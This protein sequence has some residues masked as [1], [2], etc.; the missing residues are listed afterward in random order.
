MN[1]SWLESKAYWTHVASMRASIMRDAMTATTEA[2]T[3]EAFQKQLYYY[4]RMNT[5]VELSFR[6]ETPIRE[7]LVHN[8]GVLKDR[9]SGR[10]RLDAVVNNLLIEYKKHKKLEKEADQQTAIHQV[11]DYLQTLYENEKVQYSAILTDGV[12]I[13]YF[14]FRG[15]TIESTQ[16]KAMEDE[17]IDRIIRAILTNNSKKLISENIYKDFSVDGLTES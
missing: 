14:G 17:D 13:S 15:N 9:T 8:F 1:D 4:I 5:G 16:L 2:Q 12:Q 6:P 10:G 3:E 7:G 11:K